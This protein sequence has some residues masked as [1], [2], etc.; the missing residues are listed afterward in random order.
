MKNRLWK[1]SFAM[2]LMTI[3]VCLCAW[4]AAD[5]IV[6]KDEDGHVLADGDSLSGRFYYSVYVDNLPDACPALQVG[7]NTDM[8]A[9]APYQNEW[10]TR[11]LQSD[12]NDRLYFMVIADPF[13][14]YDQEIM[15]VRTGENAPVRRI[16]MH[17]D[18]QP[19]YTTRPRITTTEAPQVGQTDYTL[20]WTE[21]SG[22]F[23]FIRWE[24][25]NGE[26]YVLSSGQNQMDLRGWHDESLIQ[27]AGSY[28]AEVVPLVN[29]HMGTSSGAQY[30]WVD[31]PE[32]DWRVQIS[33]DRGGEGNNDINIRY[34]EAVNYHISAPGAEEIRFVDGEDIY[35]AE[36]NENGEADVFWMP[37]RAN[38]RG[39]ERTYVAFAQA[40]YGD[41]WENSNAYFI[42]VQMNWEIYGEIDWS[43]T[44]EKEDGQEIAE[45]A[46]DG[47]V[48]IAV[49]PLENDETVDFFGAYI[50]GED[51][52]W[53]D[54]SHWF[55]ANNGG[56]TIIMMPVAACPTGTYDI[57][58]F[59][60]RFASPNKESEHVEQVTVTAAE[61]PKPITISMKDEFVTREPLWIRAYYGNTQGLQNARM[62]VKIH[63]K[64]DEND[65]QYDETKGFDF[66]DSEFRIDWPGFY[67]LSAWIEQDNGQGGSQVVPNTKTEFEFQVKADNQLNGL[68]ATM[69]EYAVTGDMIDLNISGIPDA[70]F[71]SYWVHSAASQEFLMGDGS[72]NPNGFQ[73]DTRTLEPGV[74]WVEVDAAARNYTPAH[75][76][77]YFMLKRGD[78]SERNGQGYSFATSARERGGESSGLFAVTGEDVR[79]MYYVPGAEKVKMYEYDDD[80]NEI[81]IG[82]ADGP[83]VTRSINWNEARIHT[84]CGVAYI[85]GN[86]GAAVDLCQISVLYELDE[87]KVDMPMAVNAGDDVTITFG[88]TQ[89]A[90]S[91]SYW[92]RLEGTEDDPT[93][94]DTFYTPGPFTVDAN[95][96]EPNRVY[97]FFF[98]VKGGSQYLDS[99][100][101]RLLYVIGD[102][103]GNIGL[104]MPG[105]VSVGDV[106]HVNAGAEGAQDI[107]IRWDSDNNNVRSRYGQDWI[108]EEYCVDGRPADR[109]TT[110]FTA[111]ARI[112]GNQLLVT[113]GTASITGA[114][115]DTPTSGYPTLAI[116]DTEVGRNDFITATLG[117]VTGGYEYHVNIFDHAGN[118]Y[119]DYHQENA[120]M[121][122]IP[123][124]NLPE[125][126][127][128]IGTWVR[129]HGQYSGSMPDGER[130]TV[131]IGACENAFSVSK[132]EVQVCEPLTVSICAPG[133]QRIRFSSGYDR[134]DDEDG[135]GWE[136]D[137]WYNDNISWDY[138]ADRVTMRAEALRNGRWESLGT[139]QI[140][141]S[142]EG[143]LDEADLSDIP[144][145][146][147]AGEDATFT[148]DA[149]EHAEWYYIDLL[150]VADDRN[151]GPYFTVENNTVTVHI[152]GEDLS[153]ANQTYIFHVTACGTGYNA[154]YNETAF[155][156]V[157]PEVSL[158]P[159][160]DEWINEDEDP[161]TISL[162]QWVNLV[163]TAPYAEEIRWYAVDSANG[164]ISETDLFEQEDGSESWDYWCS[165]I[166]DGSDIPD[167]LGGATRFDKY[168]CIKAKYGEEWVESNR[169]LIQVELGD[170]IA[171][172]PTW[173]APE[174]T[175]VPQDGLFRLKV[176]NDPQDPDIYGYGI[177]L[178]GADGKEVA[179]S[180][181]VPKE[182][183]AIEGSNGTY[184]LVCLPVA[185]VAPGNYTGHVYAVKFGATHKYAANTIAITVSA[186]VSGEPIF[187]SM[188][189][190][191][192][193]GERLRIQA[194]YPN[195]EHYEDGLMH[196]E[197]IGEDGEEQWDDELPGFEF[198]NEWWTID[199]AGD[200]EVRV[201]ALAK[202]GAQE[203]YEPVATSTYAITVSASKN[204]VVI[205]PANPKI[206]GTITE[207]SGLSFTVTQP[208][209][210]DAYDVSVW[211]YNPETDQDVI[212]FEEYGVTG[213]TAVAIPAAEMPEFDP[214][215]PKHIYVRIYGYGGRGVN[216]DERNWEIPLVKASSNL[217]SLTGPETTEGIPVNQEVTFR[218]TTSS[219]QRIKAVC[220]YD[221]YI[222]CDHQEPNDENAYEATIS[223]AEARRHA[224]FALVTFDEWEPRYDYEGDGRTWYTTN[225]IEI[226]T[227]KSG[228]TGPFTF[229]TDCETDENGGRHG[230]RGKDITITYQTADH[231]TH[232]WVDVE[233]YEKEE[234][235]EDWSWVSH[236]ADLFM[237]APADGTVA[238][239]GLLRT[240]DF[241]PGS[242]RIRACAEGEG[243][244]RRTT[245]PIY[246][247]IDERD[248][249]IWS[250]SGADQQNEMWTHD[251]LSIGIYVPG[252]DFTEIVIYNEAGDEIWRES[253]GGSYCGVRDWIMD[254]A[255][256]I[257]IGAN[258]DMPN[259]RVSFEYPQTIQIKSI[260]TL[261]VPTITA[262]HYIVTAG[263][264]ITFSFTDNPA[265]FDGEGKRKE[266]Y[267]G[268]WYNVYLWDQN[269]NIL[270]E[271][272]DV[273]DNN[274][275]FSTANLEPDQVYRV[276]VDIQQHRYTGIAAD[277]YVMVVSEE[278]EE[279]SQTH[280]IEIITEDGEYANELYIQP[281]QPVS[282][283]IIAPGATTFQVYRDDWWESINNNVSDRFASS[284]EFG[285]GEKT[286]MVR[287]KWENE[288]GAKWVYSKPIQLHVYGEQLP[289]PD[290]RLGS[291][292]VTRGE[293][294]TVTIAEGDMTNIEATRIYNIHINNREDNFNI[295]Y[296]I[297]SYEMTDGQIQLQVNTAALPAGEYGI[298]AE[299]SAEGYERSHTQ[300]SFNVTGEGAGNAFIT[301]TP[302][303]TTT[304]SSVMVTAYAPGATYIRIY[305]Q[306]RQEGS[307]EDW[308]WRET[309]GDFL[310][311]S[312]EDENPNTYTLYLMAWYNGDDPQE[313]AGTRV[314][315]TATVSF[316]ADT[317]LDRP[318]A[319][320]DHM[321]SE[322]ED[323]AL[324]IEAVENATKYSVNIRDEKNDNVYYKE[325]SYPFAVS[326]P[327]RYFKDGGT[328][329]VTIGVSA[330][331]YQASY[332]WY[333]NLII[334]TPVQGFTLKVNDSTGEVTIPVNSSYSVTATAPE[335]ATGIA[336]MN[337]YG[338]WDYQAGRTFV[339]NNWSCG[340]PING[341]IMARYTT[342][343]ALIGA[344]SPEFD[345]ST[346]DWNEVEW[347]GYSEPVTVEFTWNGTMPE[348]AYTVS[349]AP[350]AGQEHTTVARGEYI[351]VTITNMDEVISNIQSQME[352]GETFHRSNLA[353]HAAITEEDGRWLTNQYR[354]NGINEIRIPTAEIKDTGTFKIIITGDYEEG[355]IGSRA[356][357]PVTLTGNNTGA[358]FLAGKTQLITSEDFS[359]SL[360]V[361][362][363]TRVAVF[364]IGDDYEN[365]MWSYEKDTL[366][367]NHS[368]GNS[369]TYKLRAKAQY[370]EEWG[371]WVNVA[372]LSDV[373]V[374]VA[375]E[376]NQAIQGTVSIPVTIGEGEGLPIS[377][378]TNTEPDKVD[379]QIYAMNY[380]TIWHS[381]HNGNSNGTTVPASMEWYDGANFDQMVPIGS[382]I[383][384][385]GT[386]YR[387]Q[388]YIQ[389][390]GW[391]ADYHE[392]YFA[393]ISNDDG[394]LKLPDSLTTIEEEAF[395]GINAKRVEI[396]ETVTTINERAFADIQGLL[397]ADF[398]GDGQIEINGRAFENTQV[399]IV[400]YPNSSAFHF[401][402][403]NHIPYALKSQE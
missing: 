374:T 329:N 51:G 188:K 325:A 369:G 348:F 143:D 35:P 45:V 284:W 353:F 320:F 167:N 110:R 78:D 202:T 302:A 38:W 177:T 156:V 117:N 201:T 165:W 171:N 241:E 343:E 130:V 330:P 240:A 398:A 4:A 27:Y 24:L 266:E 138:S 106:F 259:G 318:R 335:G 328:Y 23:Y 55:E 315:T 43:I 58:V 253:E 377:W 381:W 9:D 107:F 403:G 112:Y 274:Q 334:S 144:A 148:F 324:E 303:A 236:D 239:T 199:R 140:T 162:N 397:V 383:F 213:S 221:G 47:L 354:W 386:I 361:P 207:G 77:L 104:D 80:G 249:V 273:T 290:L 194:V 296:R 233:R 113:R 166:P 22:A 399:L 142:K 93:D 26:G 299:V 182:D 396:G 135:W 108:N 187:I 231:A 378:S 309:E 300:K 255:N 36:L 97:R 163:A 356:E 16:E 115:D 137:S 88:A 319:T 101:E 258:A 85:N 237:D 308:I 392:V 198:W 293:N 261:P 230:I 94:G 380:G 131:T 190:E 246:L 103:N 297:R 316:N 312:F 79:M 388:I 10:Q 192:D 238:G 291:N 152:A 41:V 314:G 276:S 151:W 366:V 244:L 17:Y 83:G 360:Y 211:Y 37:G 260:A 370:S 32:T 385:N 359:V 384:E 153:D 86:W 311:G 90:T 235:Y 222:Y 254:S 109:T 134:W 169:L 176:I 118:W 227:A 321:L 301:A 338:G 42:H 191:F 336:V 181:W 294:L 402:R 363:A 184:T 394:I 206:P 310:S 154:S 234:E 333:G 53:I 306:N 98:D 331:G 33:A 219:E 337:P 121:F 248:E 170:P 283:T 195:P 277:A 111:F 49:E 288:E 179:D 82:A 6:L 226:T 365:C 1:I 256:E 225:V 127:Y 347:A 351:T 66:W 295:S 125:G 373:T 157:R 357:S 160:N 390:F 292:R 350:T 393:V 272:H 263:E 278:A 158:S 379:L 332:T 126:E 57:H 73:I 197:V 368:Y 183:N 275:R 352:A 175:T 242:Y 168:I 44:N 372:G 387:A 251:P 358:F 70:E 18:R 128:E 264:D 262:D 28:G 119:E 149:V 20:A 164:A 120:G 382:P 355:W 208:T 39:G 205:E 19:V 99:H 129:V 193:T 50:T 21:V 342:D 62:H 287:A 145:V 252:A 189:H 60:V 327:R 250:V 68:T 345:W 65:I 209:N 15:F 375:A 64:G 8:E 186:P 341:V 344:D 25:P 52:S 30:Y 401:A 317:Q 71:Y 298:W 59:A 391:E 34:G 185:T 349:P 123:T 91:Y 29:G 89:H 81:M 146:V 13:D 282:F 313:T 265:M 7:W 40:R 84:I 339:R 279:A 304:G 92:F 217:V 203:D 326:L 69:A 155:T 96:L 174:T 12:E 124:G 200:Y 228:V 400:C 267:A 214:M 141:I 11:D 285:A 229:E 72:N 371:E 243:Y 322:N 74:Y 270:R 178:K 122:L 204:V 161:I 268:A 172:E 218:V 105:E 159:W 247:E 132:S 5:G 2:I 362:G 367:Q 215:S 180:L 340:E 376:P 116:T 114:D 245:R 364:E 133:A 220:I 31:P 257:T 224:V 150:S 223:F 147:F 395:A 196:I 76:T 286:F 216:P 67:T 63:R 102:E 289:E 139:R 87:P 346:I 48:Y 95:S 271:R 56:Q 210:S 54:D 100:T 46:Q 75:T 14:D 173:M 280:T 269:G 212:L 281:N 307:N 61:N 232:Y 3:L 136:G 305:Q 389:K 323:F